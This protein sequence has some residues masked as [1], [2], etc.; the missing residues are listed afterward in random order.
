MPWPERKSILAVAVALCVIVA[1]TL[2]WAVPHFENTLDRLS[3]ERLEQAG[4]DTS[5]LNFRWNYRDLTLTGVL[6]PNVTV[7]RLATVLRQKEYALPG[8]F[9]NGMRKLRLQLH[10]PDP[11]VVELAKS[12][13]QLRVT[14]RIG[15]SEMILDGVV[16]TDQQRNR[17]VEA[18]LRSGIE[19]INDNL[20]IAVANSAKVGGDT[21]IETLADMLILSGPGNV[22]SAQLSL[23]ENNL[24][25]RII[26]HDNEAAA[27]IETTAAIAVV[28]FRV[29]GELNLIKNGV[30]D[31]IARSD[32]SRLLLQGSVL[33]EEQ[34]RRLA[35]AV[36]EAVGSE[37]LIDRLEVTDL[38]ARISGADERV[39]SMATIL[40]QFA[41]G[42][43]GEVSLN[44]TNLNVNAAVGTEEVR[45]YLQ[46]IAAVARKD[47]L[48]VEEN[49]TLLH[50]KPLSDSVL[51][52]SELDSLADAIHANIVFGSGNTNLTRAAKITL[53]KVAEK[54]KMYPSLQVEVE[55]HTDNVGRALVNERVSQRRASAVRDYLISQLID[56]ERLVAVGYGDRQPVESNDTAAG[57]Q[58]NRRVHFNVVGRLK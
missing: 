34:Q 8:L 9:A 16:Q 14:V 47:G 1:V 46:E 35:F 22:A 13:Q 12:D 56:S 20:E 33:S 58:R 54:M 6:P 21:K 31:V 4:I 53:D 2:A 37:N 29:T 49:L 44:G 27:A 30:V 39:D 32:G 45:S 3:K 40:T 10:Q 42:V 24:H 52:Q 51:L 7:E 48:N 28:D 17:L 38:S 36:G 25:Y 41:P 18:A 50:E 26:A 5:S 15:P 11:V 57:R 19:R 43:K 55:G 23:D